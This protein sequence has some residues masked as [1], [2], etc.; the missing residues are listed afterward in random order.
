MSDIN[1]CRSEPEPVPLAGAQN[2]HDE[3]T[4]SEREEHN[5]SFG[6]IASV[7]TSRRLSLSRR[8]DARTPRRSNGPIPDDPLSARRRPLRYRVQ[9]VD[10]H[11]SG[12]VGPNYD[13]PGPPPAVEQ[14]TTL[15]P[16]LLV[17]AA[18]ADG[19]ATSASNECN[20]AN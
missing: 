8:H 11:H 2:Q 10:L 4:G 13:A 15:L 1:T 3:S 6:Q 16:L 19:G 12:R 17:A 5:R 20:E 14:S 7:R 18:S 9:R